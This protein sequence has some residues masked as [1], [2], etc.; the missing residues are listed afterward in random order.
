ML[1]LQ[2]LFTQPRPNIQLQRMKP[3]KDIQSVQALYCRKVTNNHKQVIHVLLTYVPG[4]ATHV[5]GLAQCA[6]DVAPP[7]KKNSKAVCLEVYGHLLDVRVCS[8][9][10]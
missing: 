5:N 2:S 10:V 4:T 9:E 1:F 8:C 7:T 6:A 3:Q